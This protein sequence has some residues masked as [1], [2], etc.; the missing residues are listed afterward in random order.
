MY[1]INIYTNIIYDTCICPLQRGS[2]SHFSLQETFLNLHKSLKLSGGVD[3]W[4]LWSLGIMWCFTPAMALG[5]SSWGR[6]MW[7]KDERHEIV[8]IDS[9]GSFGLSR[10]YDW[11]V[12]KIK[13]IF[14]GKCHGIFAAGQGSELKDVYDTWSFLGGIF[15]DLMCLGI[16]NP[17]FN[18]QDGFWKGLSWAQVAK[19][20]MNTL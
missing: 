4:V 20:R 17:I 12:A 9:G 3:R 5:W 13:Q 11:K 6:E 18:I 19:S 14:D 2:S 10:V 15:T 7:S 1:S 8:T 16:K